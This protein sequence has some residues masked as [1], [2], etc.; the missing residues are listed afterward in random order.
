MCLPELS[1][2]VKG[3]VLSSNTR[4]VLARIDQFCLVYL[5]Q[6][7]LTVFPCVLRDILEMAKE[8]WANARRNERLYLTFLTTCRTGWGIEM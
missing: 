1:S 6:V 4:P 8:Q 3:S 2:F 5:Q 7:I